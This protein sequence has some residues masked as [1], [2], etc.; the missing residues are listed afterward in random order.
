MTSPR[1]TCFRSSTGL[2]RNVRVLR[3][4]LVAIAI[5]AMVGIAPSASAA[6]TYT[7]LAGGD[8]YTW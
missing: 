4:L 8:G 7:Q 5:L 1:S 2:H 6:T 3:N